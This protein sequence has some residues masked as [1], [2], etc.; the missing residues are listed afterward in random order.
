M[1]LV[2]VKRNRGYFHS[3]ESG[4]K[5]KRRTY[6]VPA[7]SRQDLH[8]PRFFVVIYEMSFAYGDGLVKPKVKMLD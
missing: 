6:I 7:Q 1:F 4:I 2:K 3:P 8:I 5:R